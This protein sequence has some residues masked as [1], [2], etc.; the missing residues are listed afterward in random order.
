MI[1]AWVLATYLKSKDFDKK[2]LLIGNESIASELDRQNIQH[3]G[4]DHVDYHSVEDLQKSFKLDS[5]IKCVAIGLDFN[6]SYSKI[7]MAATYAIQPDCLFLAT[8]TDAGT[9]KTYSLA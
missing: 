2:V 8:N 7:M 9:R 4:L 5:D 6:F 1:L 3:T